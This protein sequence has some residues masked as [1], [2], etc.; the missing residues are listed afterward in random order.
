[1]EEAASSPRQGRTRSC[2]VLLAAAAAAC[3]VRP[4]TPPPSLFFC[5]AAGA[6]ARAR[7]SCPP[8]AVR[9][10]RQLVSVAQHAAG[11]G[12]AV[13]R[14]Q[15]QQRVPGRACR[16]QA[17][18]ASSSGHTRQRAR[19]A[20][21][22]AGLQCTAQERC[23]VGSGQLRLESRDAAQGAALLQALVRLLR[24]S[25][26]VPRRSAQLVPVVEASDELLELPLRVLHR[27]ELGVQHHGLRAGSHS[28]PQASLPATAANR[29][30][31]ATPDS[32]ER[33]SRASRLR[34]WRAASPRPFSACW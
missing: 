25:E 27:V 28:T 9:P 34:A 6:W 16:G 22:D 3:F 12:A 1:M 26:V 24:P 18:E 5:S 4:T 30:P 8:P 23:S 17:G 33:S 11:A 2:S 14:R 21:V 10:S 15:Q 29:P 20:G 32:K 13:Q 31:I 7:A 19:G